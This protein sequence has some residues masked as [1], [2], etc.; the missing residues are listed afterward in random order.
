MNGFFDSLPWK[1]SALG[2][3]VVLGTAMIT[4]IDPWVALERAS[5]SFFGFWIVGLIGRQLFGQSTSQ[6]ESTGKTA[7]SA[8]KDHKITE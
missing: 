2:A 8:P 3:L 5:V 6:G 7:P 4:G 1:L